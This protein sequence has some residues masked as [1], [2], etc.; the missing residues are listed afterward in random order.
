MNKLWTKFIWAKWNKSDPKGHILC[1]STYMKYLEWAKKTERRLE[2]KGKHGKLWLNRY[3]VSG[4]V[5]KIWKLII[6]MVV[7]NTECNQCYWIIFLKWLLQ[8]ILLS[9]FYHNFN[10]VEKK[11]QARNTIE[12]LILSFLILL[13]HLACCRTRVGRGKSFQSQAKN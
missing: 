8:Q 10:K 6:V 13:G 1:D 7:Q 5:I 12:A 11:I 3:K 2:D 4:G 9:L